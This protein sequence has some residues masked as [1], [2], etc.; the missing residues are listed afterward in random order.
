M[1]HQATDDDWS[2]KD[3]EDFAQHVLNTREKYNALN[4]P[5]VGDEM[6][7]DEITYN[8]A[9]DYVEYKNFQENIQEEYGLVWNKKEGGYDSL[10]IKWDVD[11]ESGYC[12]HEARLE[13]L[14]KDLENAA[15]MRKEFAKKYFHGKVDSGHQKQIDALNIWN[16]GVRKDEEAKGNEASKVIQGHGKKSVQTIKSS[17]YDKELPSTKSMM[18]SEISY[19]CQKQDY[20]KKREKS[21]EIYED[22]RSEKQQTQDSN[23]RTLWNPHTFEACRNPSEKERLLVEGLAKDKIKESREKN[24][25]QLRILICDHAKWVE[26]LN[27]QE[28]MTQEI[29]S[30]KNCERLEINLSSIQYTKEKLKSLNNQIQHQHDLLREKDPKIRWVL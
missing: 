17:T 22:S 10:P 24:E 27:R 15:E 2:Q 28:E 30:G 20:Q 16:V 21:P 19:S 13:Y 4:L 1:N 5:D 12:H 9:G 18:G 3:K 8:K 26:I 11:E 25:N 23:V 7:D 29:K 14:T 6:S